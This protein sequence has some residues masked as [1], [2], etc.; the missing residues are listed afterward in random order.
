MRDGQEW[1]GYERQREPERQ[2][3]RGGKVFLGIWRKEKLGWYTWEAIDVT[4]GR[5]QP[6]CQ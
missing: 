6:D 5:L 3:H 2:R 1:S 4:G